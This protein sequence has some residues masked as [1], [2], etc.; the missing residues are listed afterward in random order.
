MREESDEVI[1]NSPLK[2][3]QVYQDTKASKRS[4]SPN[5]S[6]S[7]VKVDS[8]AKKTRALKDMN[9]EVIS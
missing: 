6:A 2:P 4:A 1:N 9:I 8:P 7:P 3:I 5:K